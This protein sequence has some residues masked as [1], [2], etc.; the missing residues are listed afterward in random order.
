M[1]SV[2]DPI[3]A[4]G[5]NSRRRGAL[6]LAALER[7]ML[8]PPITVWEKLAWIENRG[9]PDYLVNWGVQQ[10]SSGRRAVGYAAPDL[11]AHRKETQGVYHDAYMQTSSLSS[12][13]RIL[14][15]YA[16]G[17]PHLA[18]D[19]DGWLFPLLQEW[20]ARYSDDDQQLLRALANG[21]RSRGFG[22]MPEQR[23]RVW[24][25]AQAR[26]HLAYASSNDELKRLYRECLLGFRSPSAGERREYKVRYEDRIV[27]LIDQLTGYRTSWHELDRLKLSGVL[28]RAFSKAFQVRERDLHI[29]VKD[30]NG[31][32]RSHWS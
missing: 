11:A 5:S 25:L 31:N 29:S 12:R 2:S 7:W 26:Q 32:E 1:A 10:T 14:H 15:S 13:K 17:F 23:A 22:W 9:G 20:R 19:F 18:F 16:T 28:R 6:E 21:I 3:T 4:S 8:P 27:K 24:R 30:V